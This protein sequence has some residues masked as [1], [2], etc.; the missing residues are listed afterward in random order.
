M[1][2]L[3]DKVKI[4]KTGVVGTVLDIRTVNGETRYTVESDE[5]GSTGGYPGR[6]PQYDCLEDGLEVI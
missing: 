6:W 1:I 3:Y 2:E 4:K 5:K